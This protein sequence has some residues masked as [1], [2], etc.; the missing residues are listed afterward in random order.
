MVVKGTFQVTAQADPPYDVVD[1]VALARAQVDKRFQGP[2]EATSRVQMLAARTAD[3]GSA[4]YVAMER[5]AGS[6]E[7][8]TGTFVLQHSGTM[9]R[10]VP[11]LSVVVVANS[12]TGELAGIAG[13]M[14]IE[15]RGG[16]H[17]YAFDY[18]LGE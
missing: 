13:R 5:V 9:T 6:L 17:F 7:G 11:S 2:L 1:G 4:A 10:G 12:G 8:K 3:E 18:T 14:A 16:E 15:I